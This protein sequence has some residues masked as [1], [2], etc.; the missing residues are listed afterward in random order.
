MLGGGGVEE[1]GRGGEGVAV[2]T[3]G[4]ELVTRLCGDENS[5]LHKTE[6]DA[7]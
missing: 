4:I 2:V 3:G 6:D 1:W 5:I 7:H